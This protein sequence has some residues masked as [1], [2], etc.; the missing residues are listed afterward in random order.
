[1]RIGFRVKNSNL[2]GPCTFLQEPYQVPMVVDLKKGGGEEGC[3]ES[4]L[5]G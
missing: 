1:M 3:R 5:T 2:R 4:N